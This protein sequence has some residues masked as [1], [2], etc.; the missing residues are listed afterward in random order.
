MS[1]VNIEPLLVHALLGDHGHSIVDCRFEQKA[2]IPDGQVWVRVTRVEFDY[3]AARAERNVSFG[4]SELVART[5]MYVRDVVLSAEK[6]GSEPGIKAT[7]RIGAFDCY[8]GRP[9]YRL[10]NIIL[11][12]EYGWTV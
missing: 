10:F 5:L 11:T 3:E 12:F 8:V 1:F 2:V 9:M 6:S 4:L 7:T